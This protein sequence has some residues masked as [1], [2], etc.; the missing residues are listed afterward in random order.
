MDRELIRKKLALLR[1]KKSN[2]HT[3]EPDGAD[4]GSLINL[5]GFQLFRSQGSIGSGD[6]LGGDSEGVTPLLRYEACFID[7]WRAGESCAYR[8]IAGTTTRNP[9][10]LSLINSCCGTVKAESLEEL[11]VQL[12]KVAGDLKPNPLLGGDFEHQS[13]YWDPASKSLK[14]SG[15]LVV[16]LIKGGDNRQALGSPSAGSPWRDLCRSEIPKLHEL[17]D[18]S[19]Q[20]MREKPASDT[21]Q[22]YVELERQDAQ[23]RQQVSGAFSAGVES[24]ERLSSFQRQKKAACP[25][26]S[27]LANKSDCLNAGDNGYN[28]CR[29]CFSA[30]FNFSA[31][32]NYHG[33]DDDSDDYERRMAVASIVRSFMSSINRIERMTAEGRYRNGKTPEYPTVGD[34]IMRIYYAG[35]ML[36]WDYFVEESG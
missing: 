10:G 13:L 25:Q 15:N 22:P 7:G 1:E 6:S 3:V 17:F 12:F 8:L 35:M 2:E 26:C 27:K 5:G 28:L 34:E 29:Y 30:Y 9:K 20:R 32:G 16:S 33:S 21:G 24:L 14:S 36:N 11:E 18:P 4:G 23:Y 19:V 31:L